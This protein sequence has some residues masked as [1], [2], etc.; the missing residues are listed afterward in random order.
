VLGDDVRGDVGC[1][2]GHVRAFS[3]GGPE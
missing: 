3:D 1:D 2:A